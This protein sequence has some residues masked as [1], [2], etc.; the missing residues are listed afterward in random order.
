MKK[1]ILY[2][3]IILLVIVITVTGTYAFFVATTGSNNNVT[4]NSAKLEVIYTGGTAIQG[5]LNL[6]RTKEE[7]FNTTV[8]IKLSEDS[9]DAMADIYI[10][11]NQITST[12]ATEALI[13]EVYKKYEGTETFVDSG[14]FL[15][16]EAENTTKKCE[17]GDKIYIV[18][19]YE[20]TTTDTYYTV[21]I[22]LN[23]DKV[24]NE[25]LGATLDAYIGAETEHITT[26]LNNS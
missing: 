7:G 18:K 8:T 5:G 13:W 25:A 14:T 11:I 19:N 26:Q 15:D 4:A 9:V 21:Y 23:G 12:I 16:C 22:W 3:I 20:L 24:G 10:H 6:V 2:T 1:A 17:N